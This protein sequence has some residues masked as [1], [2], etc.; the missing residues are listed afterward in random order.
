MDPNEAKYQYLIKNKKKIV[1]RYHIN[2]KALVAELF[3]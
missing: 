1:L 3:I 2:P